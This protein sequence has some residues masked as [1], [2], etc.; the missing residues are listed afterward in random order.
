MFREMI[1]RRT[2]QASIVSLLKNNNIDSDRKR[3]IQNA[4]EGFNPFMHMLKKIRAN[5]KEQKVDRE[6][7]QDQ[8]FEAYK[9]R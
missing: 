5:K 8:D 2:K 9:F 7:M 1:I 4:K 3:A 6:E